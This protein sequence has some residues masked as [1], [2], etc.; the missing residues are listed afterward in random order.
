MSNIACV[1]VT[2]YPAYRDRAI[3]ELNRL[4]EPLPGKVHLVI[5]DNGANARATSHTPTTSTIVGDNSKR[6]FSG[7]Q[8][9]LDTLRKQGA[10]H[11]AG[12]VV[13]ANDTF[14]HHNKFGPVTRHLWRRAFRQ[15]LDARADTLIGD[16]WPFHGSYEILGMKSNAWISTYLF[17]LSGAALSR[18]P[19]FCPSIANLPVDPTVAE[20]FD[21]YQASPSLRQ[22][23][24]SWMARHESIFVRRVALHE[25]ASE[26]QVDTFLAGKVHAILLEKAFAAG[27]TSSGLRLETPFSS[28]PWSWFRRL[29]RNQHQHPGA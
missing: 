29:E 28:Q 16:R 21:A 4:L 12:L 26:G 9:G 14:C 24:E 20:L 11:D 1:L 3:K 6:E 17:A 22:H 13:F 5:V 19:A 15:S 27:C 2:Y 18:L 23:I 10:L 7:Y 8:L 25:N